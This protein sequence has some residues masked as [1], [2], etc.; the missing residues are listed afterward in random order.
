ME[1]P[2]HRTWEHSTYASTA[3]MWAFLCLKVR[4]NYVASLASTAYAHATG[5]S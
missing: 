4:W 5:G 2:E 1:V 3:G